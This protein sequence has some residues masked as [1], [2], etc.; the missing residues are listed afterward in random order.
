MSIRVYLAG[1]MGG[2]SY[3]EANAWRH[4]A[5]QVLAEMGITSYS[6]MRDKE[7][8]A[9]EM[10]MSSVPNIYKNP[11]TTSRAIMTRDY[12]DCTTADAVL[13]N[14][15]GTRKVSAGSMFELAWCYANRI[16][17]VVVAEDDNVNICHPMAN[18]AIDF[19][20]RTLN[21]GIAILKSVL[22]PG[23]A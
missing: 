11:L 23:V 1:A 4:Q 20:A 2:L 3:D 18:E 5:Q 22:L 6:P 9:G 19:R 12:N 13:F 7:F 21:E 15:L 8:L 14:F 17:T 16:P 10:S